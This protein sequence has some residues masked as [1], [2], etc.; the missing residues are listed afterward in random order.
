MLPILQS[1][2]IQKVMPAV[3]KVK[4]KIENLAIRFICNK[5]SIEGL[6]TYLTQTH[7]E[8]TFEM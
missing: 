5:Y 4:E 8:S 1:Q 7:F 3:E 2:A 6:F